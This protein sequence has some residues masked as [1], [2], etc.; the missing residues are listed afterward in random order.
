MQHSIDSAKEIRMTKQLCYRNANTHLLVQYSR[1]GVVGPAHFHVGRD[2]DHTIC[3]AVEQRFQL[4]PALAHRGKV[5]F[6]TPSCAI[7]RT[8]DLAY[9]VTAGNGNAR[10]EVSGSDLLGKTDDTTQSARD[11]FCNHGCQHERKKQSKDGGAQQ[12]GTNRRHLLLQAGKR[13]G[14]TN[15]LVTAG[16]GQ[17]E[18]LNTNR[19]AYARRSASLSG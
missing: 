6:Q 11:N 15:Y 4:R 5:F 9:L 17:V 8:G 18:E 12:V 14:Q 7:K 3:H 19:V 13:I 10:R 16:N 2:G 1:N